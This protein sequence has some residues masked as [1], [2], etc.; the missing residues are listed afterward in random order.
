M[1]DPKLPPGAKLIQLNPE[2]PAFGKLPPGAKLANLPEDFET[3]PG[4]KPSGIQEFGGTL[5]EDAGNLIPGLARTAQS[6]VRHPFDTASQIARNVLDTPDN[7]ADDFQSG[8]P[9]R[10]IAHMGEIAAPLA[11][12]GIGGLASKVSPAG[13]G[14]A[15][16]GVYGA[17]KEIPLAG[18]LIKIPEAAIRGYRDATALPE[19]EAPQAPTPFRP[20]P[21]IAKTIKYPGLA[22]PEPSQ[23]TGPPRR[24]SGKPT[25][26]PDAEAPAYEPFRPNP[27]IAK[28][29]NR[30][31]G[32]A[33]L[34][35]SQASGA[36][37]SSPRMPGA[38]GSK[39]V[40]VQHLGDMR[41]PRNQ[42]KPIASPKMYDSFGRQ[43]R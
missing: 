18:K 29:L 39:K 28:S 19:P 27:A 9:G 32:P 14:G 13:L 2:S 43:I 30:Y 26:A 3:S 20:N 4:A 25:P 22:T 33:T 16:K 10:A 41:L 5:A 34:E 11:L 38:A 12:K 37:A 36:G 24:I 17:M 42:P 6:F 23:A 35:P 1:P 15:V 21:A 8:H 7:L 40:E 31:P